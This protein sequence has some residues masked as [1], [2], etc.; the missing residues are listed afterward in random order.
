MIFSPFYLYSFVK[1]KIKSNLKV[2][3]TFSYHSAEKALI[4]HGNCW[5]I[6]TKRHFVLLDMY[7]GASILPKTPCKW[8]PPNPYWPNVGVNLVNSAAK[9]MWENWHSR[10]FRQPHHISDPRPA[11]TFTFHRR[12]VTF[13]WLP[14]VF[15]VLHI[16]P[17]HSGKNTP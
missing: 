12:K 3:K 17:T 8:G 15:R 16:K 1:Q 14:C 13:R 10:A 9:C 4:A 7:A 5:Q 6:R 2:Q 11:T